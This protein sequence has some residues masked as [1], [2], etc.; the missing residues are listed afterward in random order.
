MTAYG[1]RIRV[2]SSGVCS[3]DLGTVSFRHRSATLGVAVSPEPRPRR[4]VEDWPSWLLVLLGMVAWTRTAGS[5]I[6][7]PMARAVRAAPAREIGNAWWR[8]RDC[9]YGLHA[10]A[11][12]SLK[13]TNTQRK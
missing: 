9:Q 7:R 6:G 13:K 10:V 5:A 8:E 4:P 11:A 1:L 12:G 2:W 3:S